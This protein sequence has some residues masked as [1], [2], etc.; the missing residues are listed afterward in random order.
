MTTNIKNNP[1]YTIGGARSDFL[2]ATYFMARQMG[3]DRT[4]SMM[5]AEEL[6]EGVPHGL[7]EQFKGSIEKASAAPEWGTALN[8]AV[9][10]VGRGLHET[11]TYNTLKTSDVDALVNRFWVHELAP[12]ELVGW[13]K[14][15][16]YV[17]ILRPVL[18]ELGIRLDE[19]ALKERYEQAT[20]EMLSLCDPNN[21]RVNNAGHETH[22]HVGFDGLEEMLI[23]SDE[24]YPIDVLPFERVRLVEAIVPQLIDNHFG[25]DEQFVNE[26]KER[27]IIREEQ[28]GR[29]EHSDL[30]APGNR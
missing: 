27:G 8:E 3:M 29:E 17:D 10:A 25:R 1:R 5:I 21:I 9:M 18:D 28:R 11:W 4:R 23:K 26:L 12:I 7:L 22:K 20:V 2:Y 30:E 14:M 15:E 16:E 13:S 24:I 6:V 19:R